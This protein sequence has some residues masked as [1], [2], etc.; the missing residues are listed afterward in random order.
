MY[1]MSDVRE[2]EFV[3]RFLWESQLVSSFLR[4]DTMLRSLDLP[5]DHRFHYRLA[6]G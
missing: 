3:R 2:K 1:W 5:G 6:P 4:I